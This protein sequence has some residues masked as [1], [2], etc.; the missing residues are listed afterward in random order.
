MDPKANLL[1]QAEIRARVISGHGE[2]GDRERLVE[3]REALAAWKAKGGFVPVSK[4]D[5][6]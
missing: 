3:L 1:E 4:V 2:P 5:Y 6:P